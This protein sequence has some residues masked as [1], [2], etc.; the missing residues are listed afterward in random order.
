MQPGDMSHL[1][2]GMFQQKPYCCHHTQSDFGGVDSGRSHA[3][4]EAASMC[5]LVSRGW[6]CLEEFS[7]AWLPSCMGVSEKALSASHNLQHRKTWARGLTVMVSACIWWGYLL[8]VFGEG[9]QIESRG[10][11]WKIHKEGWKSVPNRG[12]TCGQV[13][14][15]VRTGAKCLREDAENKQSKWENLWEHFHLQ[16]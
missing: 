4:P 13:R 7:Q 12:V 8:Q 2:T 5:H 15:D 10:S 3:A 14:T 6:V 9:E 1:P 16:S 11:G